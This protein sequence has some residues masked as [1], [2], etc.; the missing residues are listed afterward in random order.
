MSILDPVIHPL[1][2]ETMAPLPEASMPQ[3][4]RVKWASTRAVRDDPSTTRMAKAVFVL[5]VNLMGHQRALVEAWIE[6]AGTRRTVLE[7]QSAQV[8]LAADVGMLHIDVVGRTPDEGGRLA[9]VSIPLVDDHGAAARP[10][11]AQTRLLQGAGFHAGTYDP[12]TVQRMRAER[13]AA[14]A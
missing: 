2:Q 7:G 11:Y 13:G 14:S 12:P 4:V 8:V 5:E 3:I 9:M 6:T 1:R 10:A